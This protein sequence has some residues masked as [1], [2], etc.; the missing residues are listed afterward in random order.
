LHIWYR[1]PCPWPSSFQW[2]PAGAADPA[3]A[4]VVALAKSTVARLG[5]APEVVKAVKAQNA[6]GAALADVQAFD[7]KWVATP[8]VADFM[9]ALI[10][11]ECGAYLKKVQTGAPYYSEIFVTDKRRLPPWSARWPRSGTRASGCRRSSRRSTRSRSRPTSSPSMRPSKPRAPA[12]PAR[13]LQ[14][15][16]MKCAAAQRAA[17]A[18]RDTTGLIE[19]SLGKSNEGSQKVATVSGALRDITTAIGELRGLVQDVSE[20]S[21][22]QAQ[23]I[24]QVTQ[25]VSQMER[26]T[27]SAAAV[28]E[29][30]AAS[31][32][33]LH[34]QSEVA[35]QLVLQ[36]ETMVGATAEIPAA[37]QRTPGRTL[38]KAA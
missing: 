18:A 33:E 14:S 24:D 12:K 37:S 8:G 19:E 29:E 10:E 21:R 34:G 4:K 17:Q 20:G 23:G 5:T 26:S 2:P 15:L 11:S 1:Q 31:S 3:P 32:E 22:Q 35:L 6:K 13:G 16:R 7:K 38:A 36:L 9:K 28:A 25:T 27:Q 30:S